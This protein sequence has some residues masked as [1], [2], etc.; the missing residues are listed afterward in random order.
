MAKT[1]VDQDPPKSAGSPGR[2]TRVVPTVLLVVAALLLAGLLL[3]SLPGW[4]SLQF[5]EEEVDRSTPTLLTSLSDLEEY[6]AATG[7]FQVVV[8]L[9]R[10]TR[11][12]PSLLSGERTTFLATGSVDAVVDFT[13]L[14]GSAVST[15]ADGER[16]TFSLPPARLD[17]ADVDLPNSR[18][19][20]RDRG[21]LDRVG[22][23]F[24]DSPTSERQVAALAEDKLDAAAAD[25]ELRERAEDN[26]RAM[27]EGLAGA[28]GYSEV[29]VRFDAADGL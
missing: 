29:V 24:S 2:L 27:L 19:L 3:R 14:D 11:W 21:V 17:E 12:L 18:V 22:G 1:L 26:T 4:P 10:D 15:S 20:S 9:E 7:T 5:G 13:G 8:D 25:S 23:V 16:V 6:H 28:L